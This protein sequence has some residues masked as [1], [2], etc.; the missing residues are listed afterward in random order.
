MCYSPERFRPV[1]SIIYFIYGS[2]NCPTTKKRDVINPPKELRRILLLI[3]NNLQNCFFFSQLIHSKVVD[4]SLVFP[5]RLGPP[6]K[7]A[8]RNLMADYLKK[9]I[10]DSGELWKIFLLDLALAKELLLNEKR[11]VNPLLSPPRSFFISNA[12]KWG[13][14]WGGF[15]RDEG[16]I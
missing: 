7:R 4:T 1:F 9:I 11:T 15:N 16:L 14:G 3:F 12:F 10:Q 8:L 13:A 6:Y 5:H 2:I